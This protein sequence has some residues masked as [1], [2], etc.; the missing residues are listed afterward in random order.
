MVREATRRRTPTNDTP[1]SSATLLL[2]RDD[3]F[4]VLMVRR[5]ARGTFASALVFPGGALDPDDGSADWAPMVEDFEAFAPAERAAR[6]AAIRETW[7]ETSIL[8]GVVA[9]PAVGILSGLSFRDFVQRSGLRLRLDSI[10]PF[11]HWVTPES[12]P[13]RFDTR[14]FLA[15]APAGQL[16]VADGGETVGIEWVQPGPAAL[17][18]RRREQPI[19]FPTLMN[20]ERLAES[21]GVATAV[22]AA[23][24]RPR[25]TVRPV[26][27][28]QPD[29]ST[30]IVI[31]AE[32]GY[33][34]T[35]FEP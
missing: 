26:F 9:A 11:A 25:Y 14:F 23:G 27:E 17:A 32:A 18:A 10:T 20:L 35:R 1:R 13:R 19:I 15:A 31:P 12:E 21:T 3:P 30:V 5:S 24:A 2:A 16:A 33:S 6:I 34:V 22:E 4:E 7:E 8:V 29:G 28:P